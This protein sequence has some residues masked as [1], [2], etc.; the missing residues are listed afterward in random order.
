MTSQYTK[1][2]ASSESWL[3]L[4]PLPAIVLGQKILP[5]SFRSQLKV[6]PLRV[7]FKCLSDPDILLCIHFIV[8]L[9][10]HESKDVLFTVPSPAASTEA[11]YQYMP[12]KEKE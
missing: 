4:V 7:F 10:L 3:L 1:L 11:L 12:M 8:C 5:L 6:D 9:S 2:L